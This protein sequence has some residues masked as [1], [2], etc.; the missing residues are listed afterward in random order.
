MPKE[1]AGICLTSGTKQK[2]GIAN[3]RP[4]VAVEVTNPM[5]G[6]VERTYAMLDGGSEFSIMDQSLAK[7]LGVQTAEE[8]MTVTTLDS[9]IQKERQVCY[10]T[11]SS[12]DQTYILGNS[13]LVLAESLPTSTSTVPRNKDLSD[14]AHLKGVKVIEL[15]KSKKVGL[16]IGTNEPSAH[17]PSEV[18]RGSRFEPQ[19]LRTPFGWTI[20]STGS[21]KG[22][23]AYIQKD[24]DKIHGLL[25]KLY[26]QDF[27]DTHIERTAHP[28]MT[29]RQLKYGKIL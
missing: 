9:T 19:A 4:I 15:P 12:I 23:C 8:Q 11:L 7:K 29:Y 26:N 24:N 25:Q 18:R 10:A 5:D 2:M 28:K 3:T 22:Q 13:K 17:V 27:Q 6:K 20:V 1:T 14:Y 16:I 21:S